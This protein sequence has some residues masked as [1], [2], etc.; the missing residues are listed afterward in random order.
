MYTHKD[1]PLGYPSQE[2][3]QTQGFF[4]PSLMGRES[5][6]YARRQKK[7]V[8]LPRLAR[9]ST[10]IHGVEDEQALSI[11]KVGKKINPLRP[12]IQKIEPSILP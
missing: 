5:R 10:E 6:S 12:A 4:K 8:K 1:G 9:N 7:G 11:L 3:E 2:I